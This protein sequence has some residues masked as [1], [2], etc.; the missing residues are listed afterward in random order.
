M[1]LFPNEVQEIA[2]YEIDGTVKVVVVIG[3]VSR[4]LV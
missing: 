2:Q 3:V 1:V 4:R